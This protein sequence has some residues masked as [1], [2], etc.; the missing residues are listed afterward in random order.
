MPK[1]ELPNGTTVFTHGTQAEADRQK[2]F[3]EA[4]Y[5]FSKK[6]AKEKG[7]GEDLDKLSLDQIFE[8]R[9]QAG[10]Q[11]P[12]GLV[13]PDAVHVVGSAPRKG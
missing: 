8:I 6:Y 5:A 2:K 7:W 11:S 13:E 10:W 9:K 1:I 3:L 4:R 12:D